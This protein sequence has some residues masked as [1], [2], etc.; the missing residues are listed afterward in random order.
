MMKP[1]GH[2]TLKLFKLRE[3]KSATL[4]LANFIGHKK[5]NF[6]LFFKNNINNHYIYINTMN[7]KVKKSS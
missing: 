7:N 2:S 5:N 3:I 4:S 1:P 6:K